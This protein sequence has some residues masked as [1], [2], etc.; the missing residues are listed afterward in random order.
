MDDERDDEPFTV[1]EPVTPE[2]WESHCRD[3]LARWF[4]RRLGFD[5]DGFPVPTAAVVC[6]ARLMGYEITVSGVGRMIETGAVAGPEAE[7][8][9]VRTWTAAD[10]VEL[11]AHLHGEQ[12]GPSHPLGDRT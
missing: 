8:G 3:Y 12:A 2:L 5:A 10:A 7:A 1:G 9:G 6:L 11:L 4:C